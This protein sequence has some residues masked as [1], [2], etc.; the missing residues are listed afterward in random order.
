[1]AEKEKIKLRIVGMSYSHSQHGAYALI[2]G[3][4]NGTRRLPIII[5]GFEAQAIALELEHMKPQR[6]LTHDLFRNFAAAFAIRIDEVIIDK[7][8]EGV[9]HAKLYCHDTHGNHHII[10]SRT[11]DAI[12]IALRLDCP[13]YTHEAILDAA[14]IEMDAEFDVD[15]E[16]FI[17]QEPEKRN[18]LNDKSLHELRN[19]LKAAIENENYELASRIRDEI[20][21]QK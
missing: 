9:F 5:G 18:S 6:P 11:S 2:L 15:S 8:V 19:M 4:E 21:K 17:D 1:M 12:A 16:D 13:F 7:F 14:G 20:N 10:D 3:E